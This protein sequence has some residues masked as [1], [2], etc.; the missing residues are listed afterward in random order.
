MGSCLYNPRMSVHVISLRCSL[1]E[2]EYWWGIYALLLIIIIVII[3]HQEL[4]VLIDKK[5]HL[6]V[7]DSKRTIKL[8]RRWEGHA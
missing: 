8:V 6:L 2:G 1:F 7:H 5:V 3:T 4:V